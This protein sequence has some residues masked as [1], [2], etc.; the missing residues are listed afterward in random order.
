MQRCKIFK[1]LLIVCFG[2][3]SLK[4]NCTEINDINVDDITFDWLI[5]LG[6]ATGYTDHIPHFKRLFNTIKVR[7]FLE[8]G[9]G[10]STKFFMDHCEKVTSVEFLS[11]GVSDVWFKECLQLY[12]NCLNW[13]PIAYNENHADI[14]FNDACTY[15]CLSH[16]DYALIDPRYLD[17]LRSFFKDQLDIARKENKDIDV[18]FVDPGVYVRGDM[19]KLLLELEVP[20]VMAH[21]TVTEFISTSD[22]DL[23]GWTKVKTP[24]TYEK[25]YIPFCKGT[26]FFGSANNCP[27]S[28]HRLRATARL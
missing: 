20:I 27:M 8:C 10:Y 21:D 9:C 25:I 5:E 13:N 4:G 3:W 6:N 15:Q 7:G 14:S 12:K 24:S 18:A 17:S 26:T 11:P 19:V 22:D 2:L 28:S 23:Y 1:I 16:K